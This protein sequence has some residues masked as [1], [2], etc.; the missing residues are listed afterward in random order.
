[1]LF[2]ETVFP[3]AVNA[4]EMPARIASMQYVHERLVPF[5]ASE[6]DNTFVMPMEA[7]WLYTKG[8][9]IA[10]CPSRVMFCVLGNPEL[11]TAWPIP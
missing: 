5:T 11:I 8:R 4:I 3:A 2:V 1:M 7:I 10:G 9:T 6:K